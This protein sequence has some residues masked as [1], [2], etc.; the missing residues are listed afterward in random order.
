MKPPPLEVIET[1]RQTPAPVLY[2]ALRLAI[3]QTSRNRPGVL[4]ELEESLRG[5]TPIREIVDRFHDAETSEQLTAVHR[6]YRECFT[7]AF[8]FRRQQVRL[9]GNAAQN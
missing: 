4:R 9:I 1:L 7:R 8:A 6:V 5:E 2:N 3:L